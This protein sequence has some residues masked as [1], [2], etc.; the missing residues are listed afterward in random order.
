MLARERIQSLWVTRPDRGDPNPARSS[1]ERQRP[2][3]EMGEMARQVEAEPSVPAEPAE[4]QAVDV[5][6]ATKSL[7]PDNNK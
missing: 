5:G 6:V 7:P 4:R 3:R 2:R 1:N